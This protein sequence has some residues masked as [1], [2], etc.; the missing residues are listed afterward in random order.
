MLGPESW[1]VKVGFSQNV[2]LI[3]FVTKV[4][5]TTVIGVILEII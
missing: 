3:I 2:F 4:L 1:H 5:G